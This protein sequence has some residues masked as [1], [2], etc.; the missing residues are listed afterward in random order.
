MAKLKICPH[1]KPSKQLT[2][3]LPS[4]N[5]FNIIYAFFPFANYAYDA[6]VV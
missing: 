6:A 5:K 3:L 2:L 1:L 4:C